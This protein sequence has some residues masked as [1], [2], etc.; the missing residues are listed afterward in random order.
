MVAKAT[1]R[2]TRNARQ[3][4]RKAIP[5]QKAHIHD[6]AVLTDA[7]FLEEDITPADPPCLFR[8]Q[9]Q[10][11][12][13]AKFKAMV[14]DGESEVE[15]VFNQNVDLVAGALY[16]FDMLIHEDDNVNFQVDDNVNIDKF[17]VQ[18]ILWGTQ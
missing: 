10:I 14:D 2:D 13:A 12:T 3:V 9:V 8:I 17:I 11:D 6:T 5:L 16:I 4:T 15:L 1:S 7:D 18:E